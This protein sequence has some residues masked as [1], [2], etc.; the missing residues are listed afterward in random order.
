MKLGSLEM[1]ALQIQK[2]I[3]RQLETK[4]NRVPPAQYSGLYARR[5]QEIINGARKSMQ[6]KVNI[7]SC[8]RIRASHMCKMKNMRKD[9]E[10]VDNASARR[11]F[12]FGFSAAV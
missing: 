11:E 4:K 8:H 6:I 1:R 3:T 2:K 12:R 9:C 7:C 10:H 5:R